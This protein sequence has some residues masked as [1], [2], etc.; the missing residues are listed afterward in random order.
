M[1]MMSSNPIRDA[2][3][4]ILREHDRCSRQCAATHLIEFARTDIA[5]HIEDGIGDESAAEYVREWG[6]S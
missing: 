3:E 2:V 1:G 5:A 6:A 4:T